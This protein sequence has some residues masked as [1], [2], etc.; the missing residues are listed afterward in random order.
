M[1]LPIVVGVTGATGVVYGV[2]LLKALKNLGIPTHLIISE[3]GL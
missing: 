3:T 2:E 1:T